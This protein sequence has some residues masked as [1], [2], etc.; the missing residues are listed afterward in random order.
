M[1][2][3]TILTKSKRCCKAKMA[4]RRLT[5]GWDRYIVVY[6]KGRQFNYTAKRIMR[7]LRTY[8]PTVWIT[9]RSKRN[10]L[11][12]TAIG[13]QN[14]VDCREKRSTPFE[15]TRGRTVS[16]VVFFGTFGAPID[17][18]TDRSLHL[19]TD[20]CVVWLS[21]RVIRLGNW[22][23]KAITTSWKRYTGVFNGRGWR[24]RK[25]SN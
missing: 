22:K 18:E 16:P 17:P 11:N 24:Y 23:V 15:G 13:F 25:S 19:L 14:V 4:F 3:E 5:S 7:T 1:Q 12:A 20:P 10:G 8:R 6:A 21:T 2:R 9:T